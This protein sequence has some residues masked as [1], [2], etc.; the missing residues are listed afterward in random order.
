MP[1][2]HPAG[3]G[4]PS[5]P[6]AF[7]AGL[8]YPRQATPIDVVGPR[9][10]GAVKRYNVYRNNVTVSLIDAL[11][12]VYPAVQ[13]ITGD[14]F[15]R[16]MARSHV[17]ATPPTSP[18]LF[19][20]GRDF[21][22]FIE[23]YDPARDM[24]WLADVARIERAWL[25][26]YHA[27]DAP[28]L[29]ADVLA[30]VPPDKLGGLVFT[31][32]PATRIVRSAYP[33]VAIFAMNRLDGPVTPFRSSAAEDALVT[34]PD[35]EVAAR[36]LPAGA[37]TFLLSLIDGET[38]AAAAAAALDETPAFDLSSNIASMVEA[39]VFGSAHSGA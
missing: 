3:I 32:H 19:D 18:L 37:A 28:P 33:T 10:K 39:G 27:A 38:L 20:Y 11:A 15:F 1:L 26:A 6:S 34:R 24:P 17:R 9:G 16:A 12:D 21:P 25:D 36:R 23:V 13:R 7:A 31:A 2:D 22:A 5:F 30:A 14:Q 8:L 4:R 35:M 29:S